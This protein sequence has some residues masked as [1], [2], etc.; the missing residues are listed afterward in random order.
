MNLFTVVLFTV[1][2]V[3]FFLVEKIVRYV[4]AHATNGSNDFIHGHHHHHH[5][6]KKQKLQHDG[7]DTNQELLDSKNRETLDLTLEKELNVQSDAELKNDKHEKPEVL[8][9]VYG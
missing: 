8:R 7:E 5:H 4:E 3:L 1:G 9:K 2:I 6:K